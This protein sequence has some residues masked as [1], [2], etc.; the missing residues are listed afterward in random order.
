MNTRLRS[1]ASAVRG[2]VVVPR[3]GVFTVVAGVVAAGALAAADLVY[4]RQADDVITACVSS[5]S[6]VLSIKATCPGQTLTWNKEGPQGPTGAQGVAG[7]AGAPGAA[8]AQG[9][10]GAP[11]PRGPKGAPGSDNILPAV[12]VTRRMSVPYGDVGTV[13]CPDNR[14]AVGGGG[15]VLDG[16]H[17]AVA[18]FPL[19]S[20]NGVSIGWQYKVEPKQRFKV[21]LNGG[22]F[23]TREAFGHRHE[24]DLPGYVNLLTPL[25]TPV[26]VTVYAVCI[27]PRK[28][29]GTIK[30]KP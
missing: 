29:I 12:V 20:R 13:T 3:W 28:K 5:E 19:A 23:E 16:L 26:Q 30:P 9:P 15:S 2:P 7:S 14:F 1:A 10:Q 21:G 11:G 17:Y 6:G 25:V 8:G 22:K 24:I 18:S 4:A 27:G